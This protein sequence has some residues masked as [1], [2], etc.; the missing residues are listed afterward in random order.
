ML[1]LFVES[2]S[3]IAELFPVSFSDIAIVERDSHSQTRT[4]TE[5]IKIYDFLL[6]SELFVS[7][8]F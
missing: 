6:N 7:G 8:E 2:F 4:R 5:Y 3:K 1:R